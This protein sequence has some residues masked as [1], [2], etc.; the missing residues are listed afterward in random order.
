MATTQVLATGSGATT[1]GDIVL[2]AGE[3]ANIFLKA[4]TAKCS[5]RIELK[6][7]GG[8]YSEAGELSIGNA[9]VE[10][11]GPVTFRVRREPGHVC[12]VSRG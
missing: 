12:G 8:G 3:T 9:A 10:I 2:A 7:E 4:A 11:S 1:S 5:A 6:D